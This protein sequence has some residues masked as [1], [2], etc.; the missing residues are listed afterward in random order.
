MWLGLELRSPPCTGISAVKK[1]KG[2][3]NGSFLHI[4]I[5]G[6]YTRSL[7]PRVMLACIPWNV[8]GNSIT[9]VGQT[10]CR[11]QGGIR[12]KCKLRQMQAKTNVKWGEAWSCPKYICT[13]AIIASKIGWMLIRVNQNFCSPTKFVCCFSKTCGKMNSTS[14]C[15]KSQSTCTT[16]FSIAHGIARKLETFGHTS[17]P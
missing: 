15:V 8:V 16:L 13:L 17:Q 12:Q 14:N 1:Q 9:P 4:S 3:I 2:V 10:W 7:C 11:I 6:L 5:H